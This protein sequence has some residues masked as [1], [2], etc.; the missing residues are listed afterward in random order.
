MA[1]VGASFS[2][3][4]GAAA[5]Y[6]PAALNAHGQDRYGC[7]RPTGMR[8]IPDEPIATLPNMPAAREAVEAF[9]SVRV[10]RRAG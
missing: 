2:R 5:I 9:L 6:L 10:L 1:N 3:L 4:V 8:P 7:V